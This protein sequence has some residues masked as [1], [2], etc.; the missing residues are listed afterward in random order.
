MV[1]LLACAAV[2]A[3]C[4]GPAG[5]E[6]ERQAGTPAPEATAVATPPPA[7]EP[8]ETPLAVRETGGARAVTEETDD[9]LFSYAYPAVAG[10]VAPLGDLLDRQLEER[11]TELATSAAQA[12]REARADGFPYNK[13][14]YQAEWKLVADIPG[15]LSLSNEFS[16]YSGGAHG[17]YGVSSLVWDKDAAEA[18]EAIELFTSPQALED[19]LG[20]RFCDGLNKQREER[21][22]DPVDPEADD[23]FNKCP[24]IDELVVLVGS[25]SGRRFDRLTLYAGPYVAGPY[26]EGDFRVN[27]NV[28]RAVLQTVKPRYRDSFATRGRA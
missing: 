21:R 15:W 18:M 3:G 6:Q 20:D 12:R 7:P 4:T 28:D 16:T 26:A 23:L 11:R 27:L 25:G 2:M 8:T 24:D 9:Y 1:S 5:D 19:A 10:S 14:S 17:I 22:G 13:H